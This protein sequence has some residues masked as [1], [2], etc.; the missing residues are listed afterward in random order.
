[1]FDREKYASA[2]DLLE[3]TVS[4]NPADLAAWNLLYRSYK[5]AGEPVKA[6]AIADR[7]PADQRNQP[8]YQVIKGAALLNTGDSI[9]AR[10][11]FN[12]AIGDARKKDPAIQLAVAQALTESKYGNYPWAVQLL[13]AAVKRDGKNPDL[14]LAMGDAYRRMYNGSEA[15][16]NYAHATELDKNNAVAYYKIGKIY[17]TQNN[18]DVYNE[19][20]SKALAADPAFAPV[21]FQ[22]YYAAYFRDVRQAL[23]PLQ[24]YIKLGDRDVNN[25]YLLADVYFILK[26]YPESIK[27][28][29]E[30]IALQKD[31]AK[32]RLYKLL[33]YSYD[34][35]KDS[36]AAEKN[37]QHFFAIAP[38][39]IVAA[40]DI[41]LMAKLLQQKGQDSLALAWHTRAFDRE[42]DSAQRVAIAK[43][44][45]AFHKSRKNFAQ[46]AEWYAKM[47]AMHAPMSNVDLFGWGV[48]NYNAKNYPAADSVFAV[49][50]EKYPEQTY[51][52]YWRAR[53]N[54]AIDTAMEQG[55]AVPHYENLIKVAEKDTSDV[56]N[57]RWL[58]QAYGYVAAYKVNTQKAY[59][60]AMTYFD[61]I[62]ALDPHN[63]DAAKYKD[64]LAKTI[65]QHADKK[66][67]D[68]QADTDKGKAVDKNPRPGR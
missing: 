6:A 37:L 3:K 56:T 58:I 9:A 44:L 54:A 52:Y 18:P 12:A 23:E 62:L 5:E 68:E 11:L 43:K 2:S 51:G 17:Q 19:Y 21:Y 38:D 50:V 55:L 24:Q 15:F 1:M 33:A 10:D 61:K 8:L 42:K 4:L 47:N 30:I 60:E 36:V 34:G 35:I 45:V 63:T 7:I 40:A 27:E 53:S 49:Y 20:Y 16:R 29:N 32:P 59:E 31:S 46:Q 66:D 48:A 25:N 13:E 14:Y 65:E 39:S 41:S 67:A 22:Q 26:K 57:R 28:A 64:I